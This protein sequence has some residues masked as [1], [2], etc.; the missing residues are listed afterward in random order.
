[1]VSTFYNKP[2][3]VL[4]YIIFIKR[5]QVLP[6]RKCHSTVNW[7]LILPTLYIPIFWMKNMRLCIRKY[8]HS[9]VNSTT[10]LKI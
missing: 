10:K 5:K 7:F 9:L 3:R 1:M 4:D 8:V 2:F 6:L